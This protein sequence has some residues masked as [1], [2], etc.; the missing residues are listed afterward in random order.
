[1]RETEPEC[2]R[3]ARIRAPLNAAYPRAPDPGT[4]SHWH[5]EARE[6]KAA[7]QS[8]GENQRYRFR[9]K[10][11]GK[12]SGFFTLSLKTKAFEKYST[13]IY[14][15]FLFWNAI[16]YDKKRKGAIWSLIC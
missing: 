14:K 11:R 1:V 3:G 10:F 13:Q 5:A 4:G 15:E 16:C 12:M 7:A 6:E 9:G 8:L 2:L